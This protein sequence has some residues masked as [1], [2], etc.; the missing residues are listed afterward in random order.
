M[1]GGGA[2]NCFRGRLR[3][4]SSRLTLD[5][6]TYASHPLTCHEAL[7]WKLL[8]A[9]AALADYILKFVSTMSAS[10]PVRI[11]IV[12]VGLIGPRHAQ[13]V[14]DEPD[15]E[16]ACFVDPSPNAEA[17][18]K[19]FNCSLFKSIQD[20]LTSSSKP[21]AA[22]VCTPNHT[23]VALSKEL[24]EGGL[25]VL[26]EKPISIDIASGDDLVR[27]GNFINSLVIVF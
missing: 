20:L 26:C 16:L 1:R 15:A 25:H 6:H 5:K 10:K 17:I 11:A 2:E 12:G 21:D 3:Y 27:S 7:T 18:A 22:L 9:K 4:S 24:L 13:A 23:H 8:K 19:K 14:I